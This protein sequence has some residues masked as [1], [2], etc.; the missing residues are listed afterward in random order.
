MFL[1]TKNI[2]RFLIMARKF[3]FFTLLCVTQSICLKIRNIGKT[4]TVNYFSKTI[5][6]GRNITLMAE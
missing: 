3:T 5:P 1:R 4:Q 6:G 2:T